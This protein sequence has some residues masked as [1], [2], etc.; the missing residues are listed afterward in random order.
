[1]ELNEFGRTGF[2]ASLFGMGTYYD[3]GWIAVAKLLRMQPRSEVHL[4]AINTGLDQGINFI[5]TAEIYG[6]ES[7]VA[8]AIVRQ[9][10]GRD[11]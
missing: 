11:L 9:E 7:L 3:P 8:K 4:K 2:K 6:T 5:D 1:M 10:A